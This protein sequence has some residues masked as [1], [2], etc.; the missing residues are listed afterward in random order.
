MRGNPGAFLPSNVIVDRASAWG[1]MAESATTNSC[2]TPM[3]L[4][5]FYHFLDTA[6]EDV[7]VEG[8]GFPP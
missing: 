7:I 5:Q 1:C 3:S 8:V 2:R 6:K 4:D